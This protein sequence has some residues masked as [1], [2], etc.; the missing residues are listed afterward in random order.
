MNIVPAP[1]CAFCTDFCLH[2]YPGVVAQSVAS[3]AQY[4]V[5]YDDGDF[6]M[7]AKVLVFCAN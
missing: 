5:E 6:E 2:T 4:R 7:L 1:Y 3:G